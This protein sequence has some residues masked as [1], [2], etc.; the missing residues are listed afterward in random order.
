MAKTYFES[1][2]LELVQESLSYNE[3]GELK[4]FYLKDEIGGFALHVVK[5]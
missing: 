4:F 3:K 2:G 1:R 5:K